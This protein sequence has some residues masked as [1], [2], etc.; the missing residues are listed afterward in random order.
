MRN[1][2]ARLSRG[3]LANVH[4][5]MRVVETPSGAVEAADLHF[6]DGSVD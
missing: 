5:L 4:I 6:D 1:V 3:Q 2:R